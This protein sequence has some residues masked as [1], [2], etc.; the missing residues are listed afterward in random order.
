LK[1]VGKILK[2]LGRI[3]LNKY[4]IVLTG[5]IVYVVFFDNH[6]LILRSK[7]DKKIKELE[8]EYNYYSDEIK[9]NKQIIND[10]QTNDAYLEK[11]AREKYLMKKDNEE[12]FIIR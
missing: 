10:L 5:F 2:V 9:V 12:I 6:N 4:L 1:I 8:K 7:M 3:F 11:F